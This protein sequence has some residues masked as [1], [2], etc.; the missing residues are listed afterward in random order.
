MLKIFLAAL[1]AYGASLAAPS[2]VLANH[3]HID[4]SPRHHHPHARPHHREWRR[5]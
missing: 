2:V 1:I 5:H 3:R 4:H